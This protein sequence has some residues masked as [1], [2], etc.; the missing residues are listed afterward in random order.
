MKQMRVIASTPP[1]TA[2]STTPSAISSAASASATA[3]ELHAVTT[4]CRGPPRPKRLDSVSAC[5]E[6]SMART[7]WT[8]AGR[9][10]SR[11]PRQYHASASSM[12]PPTAPTT[13]AAARRSRA[14][15]PASARASAAAAMARRSERVRR[16]EPAGVPGTSAPIRQRKPSVS[17]SVRSRIVQTPAASPFQYATSPA[18][19]GLTAPRP[20]MTTDF[21]RRAASLR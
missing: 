15:R 9:A 6:G 18:P 19:Y 20:V 4:V 17:I 13:S 5:A 8:E 3:P 2:T 16:A 10:P 14:P 21:M 12:P 11:A 1:A 7:A